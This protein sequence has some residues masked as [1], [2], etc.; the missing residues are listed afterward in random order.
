MEQDDLDKKFRD[1]LKNDDSALNEQ[2]LESKEIIWGQLDLPQKERRIFP[3]WQMAASLLFLM[4]IGLVLF[5]NNKTNLQ[6]QQFTQL[7]EELMELKKTLNSAEQELA[8]VKS[9]QNTNLKIDE[10]PSSNE[11]PQIVEVVKKEFIEKL[12]Y[13]KDTVF[14]ESNPLVKETIKLVQDTVF[15]EVPMKRT[16]KLVDLETD[17]KPKI[18]PIKSVKKKSKKMEFVFGKKTIPKPKKQSPFLFNESG[19]A[20]KT[21]KNKSSNVLLIP[22]NK[23]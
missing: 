2:E 4:S 5:F 9:T 14:V 11:S 18:D 21:E 8:Q 1:F 12:V 20:K 7:Q 19:F 17:E 6:N 15:I 13:Q 22:L 10:I 16:P 3:F 23:N